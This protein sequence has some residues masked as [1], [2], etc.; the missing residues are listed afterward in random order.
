MNIEVAYE[1][2]TIDWK[3]IPEILKSVGMGHH[4]PELHKKAFE[5]SF[6]AVFLYDNKELVGFGRAL[7]DGA[8]QAALYDCAVMEAYQGQG[9]GS[10]IVK[11]ILA[12]DTK[13]QCHI[14]CGCRKGRILRKDGI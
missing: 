1:C 8:Y 4:S 6:C 2:K 10:L 12:E 13:L 3:K 7:S 14:V 5:A 9:L 11:E